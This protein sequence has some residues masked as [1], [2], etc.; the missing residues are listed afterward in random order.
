HFAGPDQLPDTQDQPDRQP[1][2]SLLFPRGR[3]GVTMPRPRIDQRRQP[4]LLAELRERA[5]ATVPGRSAVEGDQDFIEALLQIAARLNS[6]VTRRL[7]RIAQKNVHNFFDWI[8]VRARA[9]RAARLVA[10]FR[11]AP[12]AP[13]LLVSARAR[14]QASTDDAPAIFETEQDL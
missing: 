10:V 4:Q 6:E 9:A 12:A 5:D 1:G 3:T 11:R 7:D 14:L 13:P 8:G 2:L